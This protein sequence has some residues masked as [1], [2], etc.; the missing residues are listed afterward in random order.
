MVKAPLPTSAMPGGKTNIF[1]QDVLQDVLQTVLQ[2]VLQVGWENPF[3]NELWC[4]SAHKTMIFVSAKTTPFWRLQSKFCPIGR[5]QTRSI[6]VSSIIG[7][8]GWAGIHSDCPHGVFT[9]SYPGTLER[10]KQG[11]AITLSLRTHIL[12]W[13]V[14]IG[15][16]REGGKYG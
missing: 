15:I 13:L 14:C 16:L 4:T 7:I 10:E 5:L 8:S 11:E 12:L 3:L 2:T 1:E 6:I 9:S